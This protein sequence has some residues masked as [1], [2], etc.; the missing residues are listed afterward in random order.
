[1]TLFNSVRAAV[2]AASTVATLVLGTGAAS[3][4][5]VPVTIDFGTGPSEGVGSSYSEDGFE[6]AG[7]L[8]LL[9]EAFGNLPRSIVLDLITPSLTLTRTG[10]GAFSLVSFDY[11]CASA[12]DFSV[13][14]TAVTSGSSDLLTFATAS[15]S[16]F[17]NITSLVFSWNS[18]GSR[19]DNIV[20]RHE[21]LTPIPV[22]AALPLLLAG[23]G[24][25]GLMARRKRK[26]A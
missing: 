7:R 22:P 13:G 15:P 2:A 16:G 23:I 26:S 8:L 3:A 18:G 20:L 10:G 4:A 6:I 1:M 11:S 21:D 17:T 5:T 12:C 19:L 14:T 9:S 25:L 24:G